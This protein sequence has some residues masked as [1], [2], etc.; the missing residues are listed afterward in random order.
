MEQA[1]EDLDFERAAIYRDR[2]SALS[3][4][5][6]S[7][8]INPQASRRPTSSPPSAGRH[9]LHP[10][11]LLPHRAELGQP[12]L[13]PQGRQVVRAGRR[14]GAFIAQF[15]DDKPVPRQILTST[16]CR[17]A[18][19][20]ADA[21]SSKAGARLTSRVP[22]R[23]EKRELVE[24]AETNAREALAAGWP[25]RR[26]RRKLLEG[27]ETF[28]LERIPRRIEVYDNSHIMGTN[29][30][31]AMIV[32]GPEGFAKASTASSTS[33]PT[34]RP[35]DDFG[36]MREVLTRRFARLLKEHGM[37]PDEAGIGGGQRSG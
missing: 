12:R 2:I 14:A 7:Q 27:A 31:G 18:E 17:G 24:H 37:K 19:L 26:R 25:K 3:H 9:D 1:S 35:G 6:A 4:V 8:G 23:G 30:V 20:L 28:G 29:A 33:R 11:V 5:R 32:A 16:I 10:G 13:F 22:Q 36:M 15:Y 34:G 21:L